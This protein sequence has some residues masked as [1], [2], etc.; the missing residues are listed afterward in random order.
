MTTTPNLGLPHMNP[1][2]TSA[3]AKIDQWNQILIGISP[4][5]MGFTHMFYLTV[6]DVTPFYDPHEFANP[7]FPGTYYF[8]GTQTADL[9]LKLLDQKGF[10]LFLNGTT[11]GFN[12]T[13]QMGTG[14]PLTGGNIVTIPAD[15]KFH[16]V[17]SDGNSNLYTAS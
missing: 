15:G 7:L 9:G 10:Y 12:L 2:L 5:T 4:S 16:L 3:A 13:V 14:S 8:A 11:G 1:T 17:Y 6:I